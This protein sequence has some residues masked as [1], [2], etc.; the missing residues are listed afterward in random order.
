MAKRGRKPKPPPIGLNGLG[1]DDQ[2]RLTG[3]VTRIE[4]LRDELR[5]IQ[6]DIK[7][8]FGEARAMNFDVRTINR[9]L[10]ERAV[11][12]TQRQQAD[13][14]LDSYRH[15]LGMLADTP[16][17]RASLE[18]DGEPVEQ[19]KA[20]RRRSPKPPKYEPPATPAPAASAAPNAQR[21]P[22]PELA[23]EAA[24]E[25]AAMRAEWLARG[26]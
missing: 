14:L 23:G 26:T 5:P 8:V 10:R 6:E 18:R 17:G 22:D 4:R 3:F 19:P 24:A 9:I 21:V 11:D 16:L 15:A 7:A 25:M 12:A 1:A 2:R 20:T 13:D